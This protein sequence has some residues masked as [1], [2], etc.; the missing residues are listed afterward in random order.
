MPVPNLIKIRVRDGSV[1]TVPQEQA[2][3]QIKSRDAVPISGQTFLLQDSTGTSRNISSDDPNFLSIIGTAGTPNTE[4]TNII[5][6]E[7]APVTA[8]TEQD[9]EALSTALDTVGVGG[10]STSNIIEQQSQV[11]E[12]LQASPLRLTPQQRIGTEQTVRV[13]TPN[14]TI[15]RIPLTD[16]LR[17]VGN[18]SVTFVAGERFSLQS[19]PLGR[20]LEFTTSDANQQVMINVSRMFSP[21]GRGNADTVFE[22]PQSGPA[23]TESDGILP[24]TNARVNTAPTSGDLQSNV[25]QRNPAIQQSA[26][27]NTDPAAPGSSEEFLTAIVTE[28]GIRGRIPV[29][30]TNSNGTVNIRLK[31]VQFFQSHPDALTSL[32]SSIA[33]TASG[34]YQLATDAE[35]RGMQRDQSVGDPIADRQIELVDSAVTVARATIQGKATDEQIAT[36]LESPQ[37][38]EFIQNNLSATGSRAGLNFSINGEIQSLDISDHSPRNRRDIYNSILRLSAGDFQPIN[39]QIASSRHRRIQSAHQRTAITRIISEEIATSGITGDNA[40][41]E[42]QA[43]SFI[44]SDAAQIIISNNVT[45]SGDANRFYYSTPEQSLM[46]VPMSDS[47]EVAHIIAQS[48]DPNSHVTLV[49]PYQTRFIRASDIMAAQHNNGTRRS[50]A[51]LTEQSRRESRALGE[52]TLV[53]HDTD[54]RG[55]AITIRTPVSYHL[56]AV[57]TSAFALTNLLFLGAPARLANGDSTWLDRTF[58]HVI[59]SPRYIF[60]QG[61]L[62]IPNSEGRNDG[63]VSVVGPDGQTTHEAQTILANEFARSPWANLGGQLAGL[64]IQQVL[65]RGVTGVANVNQISEAFNAARLARANAVVVGLSGLQRAGY[66]SVT[67]GRLLQ[68]VT[69]SALNAPTLLELGAGRAIAAGSLTSFGITPGSLGLVT[70]IV[71]GA[72]EGA[73]F[74]VIQTTVETSLNSDLGTI[75]EMTHQVGLNAAFGGGMSAI[76]HVAGQGALNLYRLSKPSAASSI[77]IPQ[78]TRTLNRFVG[79]VGTTVDMGLGA[80]VGER[81]SLAIAL[82][83][84]ARSI[85]IR[86]G[87]LNIEEFLDSSAQTTANNLNKL[88]AELQL[89]HGRLDTPEVITAIANDLQVA[90]DK[91]TVAFQ[92]G[93]H[94][95]LLD[96][97]ENMWHFRDP[98]VRNGGIEQKLEYIIDNLRRA[99]GEPGLV[100]AADNAA[101]ELQAIVNDINTDSGFVGHPGT[102][103]E[104][105]ARRYTQYATAR[106]KISKMLVRLDQFDVTML[107]NDVDQAIMLLGSTSNRIQTKVLSGDIFVFGNTGLTPTHINAVNETLG[108]ARRLR[109]LTE[110]GTFSVTK[111]R[112]FLSRIGRRDSVDELHQLNL[113]LN[114]YKSTIDTFLRPNNKAN[115]VNSLLVESIQPLIDAFNAADSMGIRVASSD[116]QNNLIKTGRTVIQDRSVLDVLQARAMTPINESDAEFIS[117]II[118]RTDRDIL[119]TPEQLR[120]SDRIDGLA[121]RSGLSRQ[122]VATTILDAQRVGSRNA[123]EISLGTGTPN[124]LT[125]EQ[126]QRLSATNKIMRGVHIVQPGNTVWHDAII[127]NHLRSLESR[128]TLLRTASDVSPIVNI[129]NL[130]T[131]GMVK[132]ILKTPFKLIGRVL[133]TGVTPFESPGSVIQT[134]FRRRFG[135]G[136]DRNNLVELF[137]ELSTDSTSEPFRGIF[138]ADSN[139]RIRTQHFRDLSTELRSNLI[140]LHVNLTKTIDSSRTELA[141]LQSQMAAVQDEV[142]ALKRQRVELRIGELD[143]TD[144]ARPTIAS[145]VTN[146]ESNIA[147]REESIRQISAQINNHEVLNTQQLEVAL[148]SESIQ[149]SLSEMTTASENYQRALSLPPEAGP[150]R[151]QRMVGALSQEVNDVVHGSSPVRTRLLTEIDDIVKS[152][153]ESITNDSTIALDS[154]APAWSA[155]ISR[156]NGPAQLEFTAFIDNLSKEEIVAF[157]GAESVVGL[158]GRMRIAIENQIVSETNVIRDHI[159]KNQPTFASLETKMQEAFD[160]VVTEFNNMTPEQRNLFTKN[161]SP[162]SG[163]FLQTM[164]SSQ[165]FVKDMLATDAHMSIAGVSPEITDAIKTATENS[166][167]IMADTSFNI[168]VYKNMLSENQVGLSE[169]R[170]MLRLRNLEF[171]MVEKRLNELTTAAGPFDEIALAATEDLQNL[172]TLSARTQRHLSSNIRILKSEVRDFAN[173]LDNNT[174][175]SRA[176]PSNTMFANY[177]AARE[178]SFANR[179]GRIASLGNSALRNSPFPALDHIIFGNMYDITL[180]SQTALALYVQLQA[181]RILNS[182]K[183]EFKKDFVDN[184]PALSVGQD[185]NGSSRPYVN[186][187]RNTA[188][189]GRIIAYLLESYGSITGTHAT[190]SDVVNFFRDYELST[191]PQAI[192]QHINDGDV[193]S[194]DLETLF[195]TQP[196]FLGY[197]QTALRELPAQVRPDASD[198]EII[199]HMSVQFIVNW[200]EVASRPVLP[201]S[202]VPNNNS[203]E[204]FD[205]TFLNLFGPDAPSEGSPTATN[206]NNPTQTHA[207]SSNVLERR[208]ATTGHMIRQPTGAQSRAI[209]NIPGAQTEQQRLQEPANTRN[210]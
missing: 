68:G 14:G 190:Q 47:V 83:N 39:S 52:E 198:Q 124:R 33:G 160:N 168:E 193:T 111:I 117:R 139:L 53:T 75:D 4:D 112:D 114:K 210:R 79:D 1:Q 142:A 6:R 64:A 183:N 171:D 197:L 123:M 30:V 92:P 119:R 90:T 165:T 172:A 59:T 199:A 74:G 131:P 121:R 135:R 147:T 51:N 91:L 132:G 126:T 77:N 17:F 85:R 169:A 122:E 189:R 154:S 176:F 96:L 152:I 207:A 43:N 163:P 205:P 127:I 55:R 209:Q 46:S 162:Q 203:T 88:D 194:R 143:M 98:M 102:I 18:G 99:Q 67:A 206:N 201:P 156:A 109:P 37:V 105:T 71:R 82:G 13:Q 31:T 76:F 45:L 175:F 191:E 158:Q 19:I 150:E 107:S 9:T 65:L 113:L 166:R 48:A 8:P 204:L 70:A 167:Q 54:S 66:V 62:E 11:T 5:Q 50:I 159:I 120:L 84:D 73:Q 151:I 146:I 101:S 173:G 2:I 182:L 133:R 177:A 10:E 185:N 174:L 179:M 110:G 138:N 164:L 57:E 149:N 78:A 41:T 89:V 72:A 95:R 63:T 34:Q 94:A 130:G 153:S 148:Q 196:M 7:R 28:T 125:L 180:E 195:R 106:A 36:F 12:P 208:S 56:N 140:E 157:G 16:A 170:D 100:S 192:F 184:S 103:G 186:V 60:G 21:R 20:A 141:S 104:Q 145:K 136:I 87:F 155:A 181:S 187:P 49:T 178:L 69:L 161:M 118:S 129:T 44:A 15:S 38:L 3:R 25:A 81:E 93:A 22:L 80:S 188:E 27:N 200:D 40:I 61:V 32:R 116:V 115:R 42:T 29:R 134:L 144:P 23:V 24:T 35:V 128:T 202:T 26:A 108:L 86:D 137:H 58:A 97:Q